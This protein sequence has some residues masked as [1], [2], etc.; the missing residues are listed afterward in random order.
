MELP[1]CKYKEKTA[2][3]MT[4]PSV[5]VGWL[6]LREFK[7]ASSLKIV[8]PGLPGP[9][10]FLMG[11]GTM[12]ARQKEK[13]MVIKSDLDFDDIDS[14]S[15]IIESLTDAQF[16]G[17]VLN[18]LINS[19]EQGDIPQAKTVLFGLHT[20]LNFMEMRTN[21]DQEEVLGFIS[22]VN[23]FADFS[24]DEL[25]RD[26][27]NQDVIDEIKEIFTN[28]SNQLNEISRK[29]GERIGH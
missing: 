19:L 3:N 13:I 5:S 21:E 17:L 29:Q 27:L 15:A 8:G 23:S 6:L 9:A 1:H 18:R 22:T 11:R 10:I 14:L 26:D 28:I 20:C 25:C 7:V 16:I 4:R 2:V 24:M 12:L